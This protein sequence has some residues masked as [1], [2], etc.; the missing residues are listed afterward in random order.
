MTYQ[1]D[2]SPGSV[3]A[4]GSLQAPSGRIELVDE[5]VVSTRQAST[6]TAVAC[7]PRC[8][9]VGENEIVC[10]FMVQS[11]LGVNDFVPLLSRSHDGGK[12]WQ[13]ER[14]LWPNLRENWSIFGSVSRAPKGEL[15]FFGTRTPIERPGEPNWSAITMGLKQNSLIW[16]RS[17]DGGRTWTDPV[18]IPMEIAGSAEAAGPM[19]VTRDGRWLACYAPYN[20]FDTDLV[21]DRQQL[22]LVAS[23][24]GGQSW[25]YQPLMR[26]REPA[27]GAAEA[28][29]IELADGRLLST[30]WHTD[31]TEKHDY[32]NPYAVSDDGGRTW[33][34]PLSTGIRGQSTALAALPDGAAVLLYNQRRQGPAGVYLALARPDREDFHAELN[35]PVWLAETRTQHGGEGA[36]SNWED[37]SFG[38]PSAL[39]LP[40][41]DIFVVFWCLQPRAQGIRSVRLRITP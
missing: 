36:H 27:S 17:D 9:L 15:M 38:E 32:F 11:K 19:C 20:T 16:A 35:E 5:R 22:A 14:P 23:D 37:F 39:P 30:C 41:G 8:A 4:R 24:N 28:W 34:G 3:D 6:S 10:T 12:S 26:F 7:G 13:D 1:K 21:V 18:A 33:K 40:G 31:F 29:L 2:D 25:Q